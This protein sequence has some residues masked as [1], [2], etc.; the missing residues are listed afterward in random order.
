MCLCSCRAP[1]QTCN[2]VSCVVSVSVYFGLSIWCVCVLEEHHKRYLMRY[3]VAKIVREDGVV[4][5]SVYFG[6][7]VS[8]LFDHVCLN[9][10]K[11]ECI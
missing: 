10:C 1:Y 7:S 6:L 5:E 4:S 9:Y 2:E 3:Q 8:G 11:L